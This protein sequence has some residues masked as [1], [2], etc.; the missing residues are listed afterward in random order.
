MI[1]PIKVGLW[2]S[3]IGLT[4]SLAFFLFG[5]VS[6]AQSVEPPTLLPLGSAVSSP[7]FTLKTTT[8]EGKTAQS[9]VTVS[10]AP[11]VL[12]SS[13]VYLGGQAKS[14]IFPLNTARLAPATEE[15][16]NSI[17]RGSSSATASR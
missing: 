11:T 15:T 8:P 5:N 9:E 16:S 2:I 1:N 13:K 17:I 6:A 12:S 3:G 14:P 4:V 7:I 10:T